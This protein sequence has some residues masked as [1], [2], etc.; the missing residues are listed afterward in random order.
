MPLTQKGYNHAIKHSILF[1]SIMFKSILFQIIILFY[2]VSNAFIYKAF[3]WASISKVCF[4][5]LF[6]RTVSMPEQTV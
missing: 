1:Y 4:L 3:T 6:E 5:T 2:V